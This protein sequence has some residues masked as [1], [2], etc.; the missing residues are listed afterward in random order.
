MSDTAYINGEMLRWAREHAFLDV[1]A[2]A[3]AAD[4][5]AERY[6]TWEEGTARPTMRQARL[7]AKKFHR[8][9]SIFYLDT[10]PDEVEPIAQLRRVSVGDEKPPSAE[11]AWQIR[12]AFERRSF[13]L[14]LMGELG[15]TPN[16]H[17][18]KISLSDSVEDAGR[19]VRSWLG[20]TINDQ[21][22]TA[23]GNPAL[24]LWRD[25]FEQRGVLVFQVPGIPKKEMDGFAIATIP[26][27]V[28]AYNSNTSDSRRIFTMMHELVHVLLKDSVLHTSSVLLAAENSKVEYFCN[29]LASEVLVPAASLQSQSRVRELGTYATWP[30]ADVK[31]LASRF[32]ISPSVMVR[33]LNEEKLIA[34][35]SYDQLRRKFDSRGNGPKPKGEGGGSPYL[36]RK[37]H[38]GKL[39][40][41]LALK[42]YHQDVLTLHDLSKVFNLRPDLLS[43]MESAVFGR[44]I[45]FEPA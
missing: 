10:P 9:V 40:S 15:E 6:A 41:T 24:N 13:A 16:E 32:G 28:V 42:S 43:N 21:F 14:D 3:K 34:Q 33:R 44:N 29:R 11:L 31:S 27:P 12:L 20:V 5:S 2:A 22:N 45:M 8:A 17:F 18:P 38:L 7:L 39:L 26:L 1:D 30:E 4:V 23:E 25:A 35:S 37:V 19:L 36:N